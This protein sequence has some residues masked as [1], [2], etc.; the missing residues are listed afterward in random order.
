[1]GM[2]R[3]NGRGRGYRGVLVEPG[4]GRAACIQHDRKIKKKG[5][6]MKVD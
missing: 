6:E 1:M 4:G 3:D 2:R 5:G